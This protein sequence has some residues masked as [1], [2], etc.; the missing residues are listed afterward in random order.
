MMMIVG[1]WYIS[2]AIEFNIDI[3]HIVHGLDGHSDY[4]FDMGF[5]WYYNICDK[6]QHVKPCFYEQ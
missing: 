4:E 3:Y 5:K 6:N 1:E 2:M